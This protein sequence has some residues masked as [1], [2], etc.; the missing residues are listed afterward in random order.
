M[1]VRR[2]AFYV[3]EVLKCLGT[4]VSVKPPV[5]QL[6]SASVAENVYVND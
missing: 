1:D 2:L 6:H 5:L 3:A 4:E